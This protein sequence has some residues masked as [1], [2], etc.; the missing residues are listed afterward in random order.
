MAR[1]LTDGTDTVQPSPRPPGRRRRVRLLRR[2]LKGLLFAGGLVLVLLLLAVA[3]TQTGAFRNWLRGFI[4]RQ[5][6]GALNGELRIGELHGNLFF[7][8]E[9]ADVALMQEGERVIALDRVR[10]HYSVFDFIARRVAIEEVEL[11]RLRILARQTPEGWNLARLTRP[12]TGAG[13]ARPSVTIGTLRLYD[14]EVVVERQGRDTPTT[15]R[16]LDLLVGIDVA[17]D[18]F[19]I[20]LRHLSLEVDEPALS[21][22]RAAGRFTRR[23]DVLTIENA[24]VDLAATNVA[25]DGAIRGLGTQAVADFSVKSGAFDFAEV[26]RLVPAISRIPL[27]PSFEARVTG[28]FTQLGVAIDLRSRAGDA[29]GEVTVDLEGE[30]RGVGGVM[31]LTRV[32]PAPW[33]WTPDVAGSVTGRAQFDIRFPDKARGLP[34]RGTFHVTG[35]AA[36][37]AGYEA[38]QYAARGSFRGPRVRLDETTARAYGAQVSAA[39]TIEP[40]PGPERGV[41]Y[42]LQGRARGVDLR[43]LPAGLPIPELDSNI[44]TQYD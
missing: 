10:A 20:D 16:D 43:R 30:E 37:V 2:L 13:R 24:R 44:S 26:G 18:G 12:R 21:L 36:R 32:D 35:P 8:I 19:S 27:R 38:Q 14:G 7:G 22:G 1:D 15:V 9:L 5:A 4:V 11:G 34:V 28:P 42:A 6:S 3:A 33:S 39:G 23:D 17:R 31:D 29:R 25:V 41:L 40:V